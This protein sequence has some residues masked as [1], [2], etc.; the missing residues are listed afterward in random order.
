MPRTERWATALNAA[1]TE[2]VSIPD[3]PIVQMVRTAQLAMNRNSANIL[4]NFDMERYSSRMA[5]MYWSQLQDGAWGSERVSDT[6]YHTISNAKELLAYCESLMGDHGVDHFDVVNILDRYGH[7]ARAGIRCA[8]RDVVYETIRYNMEDAFVVM[9]VDGRDPIRR[10]GSLH[11]FDRASFLGEA[12]ARAHSMFMNQLRS[13]LGGRRWKPCRRIKSGLQHSMSCFGLR[14]PYRFS[15]PSVRFYPYRV[16]RKLNP[17]SG[18]TNTRQREPEPTPPPPRSPN[19]TPRSERESLRPI[20]DEFAGRQ[21]Q[22][23][24]NLERAR[25]MMSSGSPYNFPGVIT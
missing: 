11:I 18:F 4:H 22:Y 25:Q 13:A 15:S 9:R 8:F 17:W 21:D 7:E 16:V 3:A 10:D 20:R 14:S 6:M 1:T 24:R 2:P 5:E 19:E 12:K 23:Q